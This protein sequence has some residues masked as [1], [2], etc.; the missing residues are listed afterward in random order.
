MHIPE[1]RVFA[2]FFW[3]PL[4]ALL[5]LVL[6]C[7]AQSYLYNRAVFAT[8]NAPV[9]AVAM[10]F[11]G[12][13]ILDLAVVNQAGNS[14]SILLGKRGASFAAKVDY[15]VGNSPLAIVAADF[16]GDGKL[17]LAVVNSSS[18]SVS[19]LL[20]NGDGTFQGQIDYPAG[21]KPVGVVAGDFNSDGKADLAVLNEND[22]TVSILLGKGDGSFSSEA[23]IAVGANPVS[24]ASGDFNG[25]GKID[26]LMLSNNGTQYNPAT[27]TALVS[28]GDGT[29]TRMDSKATVGYN[30]SALAVGDFD[31]DGVLDAAILTGPNEIGFLRGG[32]DG[33][34]QLS[35]AQLIDPNVNDYFA[36]T[37]LV[38]G[39]FN[40]DG[41][42]D[43]VTGEEYTAG[44]LLGAGDGSFKFG[45]FISRGFGLALLSADVNGDGVPD[46]VFANPSNPGYAP[47]WEVWVLLATGD[48][49]FGDTPN[50]NLIPITPVGGIFSAGPAIAG[51]FNGDG[52]TDVALFE[53]TDAPGLIAAGLSNGDGTFQA[54]ASSPMTEE[55]AY[56][57]LTGASPAPVSGDFN[58][59]GKIDLVA[60]TNSPYLDNNDV[61]LSINLSNGDGTF[62]GTI[63]VPTPPSPITTALALG[64]FNGDGK[65]DLAIVAEPVSSTT[66]TNVQILLGQGNATFTTG[67]SISL[68]SAAQYI[69]FVGAVYLVAADF[70]HDGKID[71]AAANTQTAAVLIGNGD[72]TFK[73]PVFYGCGH[74]IIEAIGASD[75]NGD[76]NVDLVVSTYDGVSVFLGNGDG[77]FRSSID[78]HFSAGP[79]SWLAVG[80]FNGDGKPDLAFYDSVAVGNGDGTF[81]PPQALGFSPIGM[82]AGDFNSD[83]IPDLVMF[84]QVFSGQTPFMTGLLSAPQIALNPSQLTFGSLE[85]GT[86]SAT[87]ELTVTNIGSAPMLI[88]GVVVGGDFSQTNTCGKTISVGSNCVINVTF[89]PTA[90]GRRSGSITLNDN[91]KSSPQAIA[92]IGLGVAPAISLSP[93]TVTFS[94]QSIGTT[95]TAQMVTLTNTGYL[96]LMVSNITVDGDFAQTNNCGT[97]VAAGFGCAIMRHLHTDGQWNQERPPYRC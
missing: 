60:W 2:R 49:T 28:K 88:S 57:D 30:F 94:G 92:L 48:G 66:Q 90:S 97:G 69:Y 59:D 62:Q 34:F 17:D 58:G 89:A 11:N 71:L 46:V 19:I 47:T 76:G 40:H 16:N 33:T 85:V 72:G 25:D 52:K 29:F 7:S 68:A 3:G 55:M 37:T 87:R 65:E 75:F 31:Q 95:S 77:T 22:S 27:V 20:G 9:A 4:S 12:D 8:G 45:P 86:S 63:H 73:N 23:P 96:P 5:T 80:D 81:Q 43:L 15:P 83:G 56:P 61:F 21:N 32:G 24:L 36:A 78:S 93:A 82:G 64:D 70:N 26:L 39:D 1:K 38:A 42:L 13:G 54:P 10:D 18:N 50:Y 44:I 53:F 41:K 74:P 67:A 91:L 79:G 6:P 84:S 35:H 51:D 14:V